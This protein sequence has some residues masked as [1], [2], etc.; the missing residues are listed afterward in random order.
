MRHFFTIE[1]L[2]SVLLGSVSCGLIGYFSGFEVLMEYVKSLN[3]LPELFIY[4]MFLYALQMLY[5]F[6]LQ[7]NWLT[8]NEGTISHRLAITLE[9]I[10]PSII[11]VFRVIA[12]MLLVISPS[13]AYI[14]NNLTAYVMCTLGF[15]F[16]I[17]F[18]YATAMMRYL[19]NEVL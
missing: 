12:G 13:A 9:E 16:G 1:L 14:E 5:L 17:S 3:V 4:F 6:S 18:I 19:S 8:I 11:G 15:F 10:G 7:K 2:A